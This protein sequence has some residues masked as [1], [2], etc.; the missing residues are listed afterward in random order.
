MDIDEIADISVQLSV[1]PRVSAL[2]LGYPCQIIRAGANILAQLSVP[3]RIFVRFHADIRR[4]SANIRAKTVAW[5]VWSGFL[6]VFVGK[7][8]SNQ[9]D[10]SNASR[11]RRHILNIRSNQVLLCEVLFLISFW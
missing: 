11:E 10:L 2:I 4:K 3:P 6:F 7:A 5:T 9:P 8:F 1:P